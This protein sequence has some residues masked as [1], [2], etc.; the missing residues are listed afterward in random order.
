MP[1]TSRMRI[2]TVLGV[3]L[4]LVA[5]RAVVAQTSGTAVPPA[6]TSRPAADKS[7]ADAKKMLSSLTRDALDAKWKGWQLAPGD[8]PSMTTCG[9]G[10]TP[11]ADFDD[12][13]SADTAVRVTTKDG[14]AHVIVVLARPS[15][16]MAYELPVSDVKASLALVIHKRG[17][18]Y[19]T[20][21]MSYDGFFDADTLGTGGCGKDGLVWIWT[22]AGFRKATLLK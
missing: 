19:R 16:S 3:A 5:A 1:T 7:A 17:E 10:A 2:I 12:D 18:R 8:Q 15:E 21:L 20:T 13:G 6:P 4:T 9:G 14:V 11:A 22:G